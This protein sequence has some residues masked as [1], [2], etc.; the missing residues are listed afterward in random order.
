VDDVTGHMGVE[1]AQ[2][3]AVRITPMANRNSTSPITKSFRSSFIPSPYSL[4]PK[5]RSGNATP[6]S[7]AT[8]RRL[9]GAQVVPR[10]PVVGSI[11]LYLSSGPQAEQLGGRGQVWALG[12]PVRQVEW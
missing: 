2:V 11:L 9:A 5:T 7:R 10:P 1:M 12:G 8:G 3:S 4:V 6:V